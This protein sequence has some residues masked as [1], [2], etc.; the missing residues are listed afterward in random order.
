MIPTQTTGT[1]KQIIMNA[2]L[3]ILLRQSGTVLEVGYQEGNL[4]GGGFSFCSVAFTLQLL[5]LGKEKAGLDIC[6]SEGQ[7]CDHAVQHLECVVVA[8]F[9]FCFIQK[10]RRIHHVPRG[11]GGGEEARQTALS[12][13]ALVSCA[14]EA[15]KQRQQRLRFLSLREGFCLSSCHN[16]DIWQE[17]V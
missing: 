12:T 10:A 9:L 8:A 6:K 1:P 7:G 17:G 14:E 15:E 4:A 13:C 16:V 3:P 11:R 5:Y 2:L